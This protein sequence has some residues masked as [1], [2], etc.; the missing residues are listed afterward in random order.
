M[1][2]APCV[3][4]SKVMFECCHCEGLCTPKDMGNFLVS[5]PNCRPALVEFTA[6]TS[7][8]A[9]QRCHRLCSLA[10]RLSI[11]VI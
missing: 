6:I 11:N 7:L 3:V 1:A 2:A 8:K 4:N 9:D 5:L 10:C